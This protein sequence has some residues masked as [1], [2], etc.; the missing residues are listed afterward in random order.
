MPDKLWRQIVV[1]RMVSAQGGYSAASQAVVSKEFPC[2][3]RLVSFVKINMTSLWL[4]KLCG[5][6]A[7]RQG[8]L[9]RTRV[10]EQLRCLCESKD[11]VKGM[12]DPPTKSGVADLY[13]P[14]QQL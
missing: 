13:D 4:L 11:H 8:L 12:G 14:L 5:G 3:G 2:D 10:I 6:K 9:R 1:T 7:A